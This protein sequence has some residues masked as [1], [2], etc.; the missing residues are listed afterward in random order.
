MKKLF[1]ALAVGAAL[2][3]GAIYA[4]LSR[5]VVPDTGHAHAGEHAH[6]DERQSSTTFAA[7]TELFMEHPVPVAGEAGD[8]V[9]HLTRLADFKPVN[10]AEV[11]LALSGGGQPDESFPAMADQPGIY[12][13]LVIPK[14]SGERRLTVTLRGDGIEDRHEIGQFPIHADDAAA[15]AAVEEAGHS[16]A[17]GRIGLAK[18]VQWKIGFAT[19]EVRSRLMRESVA[20]TGTIR[21][22]A[23]DEAIIAAPGV[24]VLAPSPDFPRI[25]QSVEKGQVLAWLVPQLG[26]ETDSATLE[27][28]TRKA[29]LALDLASQERRRLEGLL[30]LEAVPE[31][32]LIEARN[33]EATARAEL[34]A[35]TRRSAPYQGAKGGIALRSPVSGRVAAVNTQP[36]GAVG[37]GQVLFHVAGLATL[38]L[39]AQIP[40]SQVGRVRD[41]SGAWFTAD[42]FDGA[43]VIEQGKNGRLIAL[44]GVV[45]KESRTVPALFEF[46]NP[47]QRFRIGMYAQTRV[48]T[49]A[50]E[51]LPAVPASALVD[52]NGQPVVFVQNTGES[53]ERRPVIPGMRDGDLVAIRDGVR[54]GE[55]VVSKGVYQ[56]KLAASS[57]AQLSH[58]HAH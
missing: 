10:G 30:A 23:S 58:G 9:L 35:A 38:W 44:G 12:R 22:R 21:A 5:A 6:A 11:I 4:T 15:K 17:P 40:E 14:A 7:A 45:D 41:P 49:G 2:G 24:G 53:F 13:A 54:P 19:A 8:F 51:E 33:Q 36:G 1:T 18:A 56:V 46:D 47:D 25:G 28:G 3:G 55:R 20:A 29:R 52:D 32:R 37:Q 27:L 50:G 43:H 16:E 48:F 57:P 42:G 39:E 31:R 26:G 34:D